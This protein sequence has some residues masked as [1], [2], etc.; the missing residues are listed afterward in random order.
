MIHTTTV[1]EYP[2]DT[3]RERIEAARIHLYR[4]SQAA[5]EEGP[6]F[7]TIRKSEADRGFVIGLTRTNDAET[8][9]AYRRA[10]SMPPTPI[11]GDVRVY[12]LTE[13]D[14]LSLFVAV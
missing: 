10:S 3:L 1:S 4:A 6:I 7:I 9:A 14:I 12:E 5:A 11:L 8:I 13:D 2:F